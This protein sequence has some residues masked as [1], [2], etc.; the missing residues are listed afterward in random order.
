MGSEE[1]FRQEIVRRYDLSTPEGEGPWPLL[2]VM[3]G[4][5]GEKRRMMRLARSLGLPGLAIVS[6]QGPYPHLLFPE[7]RSNP[8]G[9]G[10]GWISSYEP[11]E[12]I[13]LHRQ[14]IDHI[15]RTL[16]ERKVAD[17]GKIV[18]L[19][20]SQ[21]VALNFRVAFTMPERIRGV[22]AIAGGIPSDWDRSSE[23]RSG[24]VDVFY[25]G[26]RTDAVYPPERL[27]E[28]ARALQERARSVELRLFDAGHEIPR[29]A[30]SAIADWIRNMI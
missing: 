15:L 25:V 11:S 14:A 30:H 16:V 12:A 5:G 21:S 17:A 28:N 26:G 6:L 13:A 24:D 27:A 9:F 29:E 8:L 22:I 20:F 19:G 3:H 18:L 4:Y 10:F 23:Y 7:D 2:I 1:L